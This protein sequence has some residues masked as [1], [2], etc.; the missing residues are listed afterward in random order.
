MA[1]D[2]IS[3]HPIR[4]VNATSFTDASYSAKVPTTTKPSG[5]G[6]IDFLDRDSLAI[7]VGP[8]ADRWMFVQPYGSNAANENFTMRMYGW[9]QGFEA[10]TTIKGLWVPILLV[11]ATVTLGNIAATTLGT[12]NF[13]ADTIVQDNGDSENDRLIEVCSTGSDLP[14]SMYVHTRGFELIEFAFD[15]DAAGN[16]VTNANA[17]WRMFED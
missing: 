10:D 17:L 12:N 2:K 15:I 8:H 13:L 1:H 11:E 16:A 9:S 14:A 3:V 7:N 4:R 5:N 6:V